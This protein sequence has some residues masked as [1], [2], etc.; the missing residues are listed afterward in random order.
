MAHRDASLR[1]P[2]TDPSDVEA[3]SSATMHGKRHNL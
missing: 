2:I 1:F 3:R